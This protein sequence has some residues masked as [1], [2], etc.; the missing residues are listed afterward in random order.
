[1]NDG[2]L[3]GMGNPLNTNICY[4]WNY[5]NGSLGFGTN[6][7]LRMQINPNGNTVIGDVLSNPAGEEI[8]NI[9]GA[10]PRLLIEATSSNPEI[11]FK[12][13]GD[14][15]SSIWSIYKN[16]STGDLHFYQNGN[17]LTLQKNTGNLGIGTT[18]PQG[19]LDVN[20]AIY[21]R[22]GTLHADYVFE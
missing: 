10:N 11:N 7:K 9:V 13:T 17:K 5:E 1:M 8:L 12:N 4:V 16:G 19:K 20:G 18:T 3:I 21:Q 22:G 14:V 15:A 2:F 6:N